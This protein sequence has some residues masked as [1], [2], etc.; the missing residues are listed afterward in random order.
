MRRL[1]ILTSATSFLRPLRPVSSEYTPD[2]QL[3]S[4]HPERYPGTNLHPE[5]STD[6]QLRLA[7]QEL[8][9]GSQLHLSLLSFMLVTCQPLAC[10]QP[11]A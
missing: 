8:S 5:Y 11:V 4:V 7:N 6:A 1:R 2:A 9:A 10:C 3:C